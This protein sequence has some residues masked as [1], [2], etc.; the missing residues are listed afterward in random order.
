MLA[1]VLA[2]LQRFGEVM[3]NIVLGTLYFVLLGPVSVVTRLFADP[4]R[5]RPPSGSAFLPWQP[6][7]ETVQ[8]ARRQG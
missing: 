7:N 6:D 5:M 3:G 4:L 2:F 1:P 8:V